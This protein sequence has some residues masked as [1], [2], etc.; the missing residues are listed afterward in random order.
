MGISPENF[1]KMKNVSIIIHGAAS[2][3]FDDNLKKVLLLHVRGT[4]DVCRFA[5]R[6]SNFECMVHVSTSYCTTLREIIEEKV[7][8]VE[9]SG[10]SGLFD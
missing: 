8:N 9:R 2:I 1:E 4:R 10:Y 3:K 6:L 7:G 5:E